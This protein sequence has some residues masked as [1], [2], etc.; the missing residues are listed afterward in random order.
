MDFV[1][2]M[3]EKANEPSDIN[4]HLH[5]LYEYALRSDSV[6]ELGTRWWLSTYSFLAAE[7][8][9][10]W[11]V[12]IERPE[13]N[14][15]GDSANHDFENVLEAANDQGIDYKFILGDSRTAEIDAKEVDLLFVD[16]QH[17]YDV[18]K[19]ELAHWGH[20]I[21]K[22]IIFHD[23]V[24]YGYEGHGGGG[25]RVPGQGINRAISEFRAENTKWV[26]AERFFNNNGLLI[27]KNS[28][29]VV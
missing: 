9:R 2:I 13:S 15:W 28:E 23:T 1:K 21:K 14:R 10:L 8:S 5:K 18:V 16:T 20:K 22:F 3:N 29:Q 7:P 11:S 27:L 17:T 25:T 12:D 26:E 24:L 19:A 6:V 4:E